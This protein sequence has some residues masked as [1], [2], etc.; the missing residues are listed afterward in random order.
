LPRDTLTILEQAL[1][2]SERALANRRDARSD[3]DLPRPSDLTTKIKM[4]A[5]DHKGTTDFVH[6]FIMGAE[7]LNAACLE[8]R[9]KDRVVDVPL[10]ISVCVAKL[11]ESLEG[12]I[13][14]RW[15]RPTS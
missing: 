14:E 7:H 1:L 10:A 3:I 9:A 6:W 5:G 15:G 4:Q 11:F 12:I 13:V 2:R 8:H